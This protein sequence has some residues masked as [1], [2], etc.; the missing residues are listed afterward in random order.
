MKCFKVPLDGIIKMQS[1]K[2]FIFF[3]VTVC[4]VFCR[5]TRRR[6]NVSSFDNGS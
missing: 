3:L 1:N 5:Q 2:V 4:P 6:K